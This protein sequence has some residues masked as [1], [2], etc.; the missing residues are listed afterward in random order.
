[1]TDPKA[2]K[3]MEEAVDECERIAQEIGTAEPSTLMGT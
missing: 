2:K 1:L 3:V